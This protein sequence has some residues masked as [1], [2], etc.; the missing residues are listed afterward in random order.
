MKSWR[1]SLIYI[2]GGGMELSWLYAWATFS[3]TFIPNRP[4]PLPEAI[5]T[6]VL[7][8]ALTFLSLGRGLRVVQILGLQVLGLLI[9]ASRIIYLYTDRSHPYFSREWIWDFFNKTRDPLE[10]IILIFILFWSLCFWFGG[11]T[12]ARRPTAYRAVTARFDLGVVAFLALLLLKFLVIFKGGP[13]LQNPFTDFL[14]FPF[15][16]FGL[17]AIGLSRNRSDV[18]RGF[19]SGY[20]GMGVIL[21]F[22]VV[23]LLFGTGLV[24]LFLPYLTLAAEMGYVVIKGAAQPMGPVLVSIL[25]FLFMR[26]NKLR[27]TPQGTSNEPEIN[28]TPSVEES[29]WWMEL[30][31]K[32]GGWGLTGL[33]ALMGL[34]AVGF[35]L[36]YLIKWLLSRTAHDRGREGL[37]HLILLWAISLWAILTFFMEKMRFRRHGPQLAVHLY[38]ALL[39][40]G[41]HSGVPRS[42][43][44]T[45]TEYGRRLSHRFPGV[46]KE[47][48]LITE[49]FNRHVYART[50]PD[51]QQLDR[52]GNAW[53]KMRSPLHW[54]LRLKSWFSPS[55]TRPD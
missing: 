12:L 3:L 10:W 36:Y 11:V 32:I 1:D 53:R 41:R 26:E 33:V 50:A 21:S 52:A 9:S 38:K 13:N 16:M 35:A 7:A 15:F 23:V 18:Q 17:T 54:P 47:A 45:P 42:L 46:K 39:G 34:I 30:L 6:F 4:F 24:L 29:S 43:N 55:V 31:S 44:E 49:V 25:R 19:L 27:E 20:Q 22:T 37:W 2:G 14:F 28:F 8:A 48:G 40:W 51:T 5:G